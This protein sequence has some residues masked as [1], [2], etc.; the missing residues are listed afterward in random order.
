M[1]LGRAGRRSRRAP[2]DP[3]SRPVGRARATR[4]RIRPTP[5][6]PKGKLGHRVPIPPRP[7][8]MAPAASGG[9]FG[10]ELAGGMLRWPVDGS[11]SADEPPRRRV[12]CG[13]S[14]IRLPGV[15]YAKLA[16]EGALSDDGGPR[17]TLRVGFGR[18]LWIRRL[19]PVRLG[20]RLTPP[21]DVS[22]EDRDH[23]R[24]NTSAPCGQLL[25]DW[26]TS[27]TPR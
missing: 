13:L 21:P 15:P 17:F 16:S 1:P 12:A 27:D 10:A 11:S 6:I 26:A 2:P 22:D 18:A 3:R 7:P 5:Q 25:P 20:P 23:S 24:S 4:H 8:Q 19:R 14:Q 9:H